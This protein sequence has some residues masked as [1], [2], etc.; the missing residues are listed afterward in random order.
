MFQLLPE[1]RDVFNSL[2]DGIKR[3][4]KDPLE[5]R[6]WD[7]LTTIIRG[8]DV[9]AEK[10]KK[11]IIKSTPD[12]LKEAVRDAL[13][14]KKNNDRTFS[15]YIGTILGR[16]NV[17]KHF[18][19]LFALDVLDFSV[20]LF[21]DILDGAER[22][23]NRPAHHK[24]WGK[25]ITLSVAVYLMNLSSKTVIDS[26]LDERT[27]LEILNEMTDFHTRIYEGQF[28]D[29]S[30]ENKDI[31]EIME[32]DYLNM[33]ALTTGYQIAGCFKIGGIL[34]HLNEHTVS[35]LGEVGLRFG[36]A[37]QIRDDLIDY[38]LDEKYTWKTP[39]LDFKRNKKRIPL[40]IA[41]KNATEEEKN[42][43]VK[44]QKRDGLEET[45]YMKILS[46][47]M[48]PENLR[49]ISLMIKKLEDEAMKLAK[50]SSL[51][52]EGLSLLRMLFLLLVGNQ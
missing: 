6:E 23:A 48:K 14:L 41:W 4:E 5:A 20:I 19:I 3:Y 31:K 12:F 40:I 43:I 47:I 11:R 52:P 36:M 8:V 30:Y 45:D 13:Y 26:S 9:E 24:R 50:D 7:E 2:S 28:L 10:I 16:G 44:L 15:V 37:G 42:E 17:G 51:S 34:A 1:V 39:L 38:I 49:E 46:I 32:K 35:I 18:N 27:R 21:D 22:R 25:D 33:V 29:L